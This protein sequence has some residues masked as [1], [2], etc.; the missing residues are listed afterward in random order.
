MKTERAATDA[1]K[2]SDF[3]RPKQA[4]E[5]YQIG[6][7]TLWEWAAKRVGFPKPFKAGPR[8]TLF[9]CSAI[10]TYLRGQS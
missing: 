8:V 10:D 3:R 2:K 6:E 5:R 4:A 7:S 1:A 9:D